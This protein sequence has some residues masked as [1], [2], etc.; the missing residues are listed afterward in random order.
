MIAMSLICNESFA[1]KVFPPRD[2]QA[3]EV[4]ELMLQA[5]NKKQS[6]TARGL[7][8]QKLIAHLEIH[9]ILESLLPK[10]ITTSF[11]ASRLTTWR[12]LLIE[13]LSSGEPNEGKRLIS[14]LRNSDIIVQQQTIKR[15][16]QNQKKKITGNVAILQPLEAAKY[17]LEIE[18]LTKLLDNL[19]L[20][21]ARIRPALVFAAENSE[22]SRDLIR[23]VLNEMNESRADIK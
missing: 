21:A 3:A 1:A 14:T 9:Q 6:A 13:G 10:K 16:I 19:Y 8:T 22:L 12:H 18:E 11:E 20:K 23:S 2:E 4:R 17:G 15:L 5:T 7:A